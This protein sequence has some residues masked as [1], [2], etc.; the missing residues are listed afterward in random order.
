MVGL[1]GHAAEELVFGKEK[2]T[3][4]ATGDFRSATSIA[5]EMVTMYG[6][7]DTIGKIFVSTDVSQQT[8]A[9]IDAEVQKLITTLYNDTLKLLHVNM[10]KLTKIADKLLEFETLSS[11]EISYLIH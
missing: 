1:A 7:S 4:G 3:N 8:K 11:E 10:E 6:Y 9:C 5:R 2:L